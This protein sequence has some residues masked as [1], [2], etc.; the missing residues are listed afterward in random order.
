VPSTRSGSNLVTG[1]CRV[2][3]ASEVRDQ[4]GLDEGAFAGARFAQQKNQTI[5]FANFS[6]L[7]DFVISANE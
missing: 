4:P 5:L 3:N 7:I 1:T 6:Q 2:V